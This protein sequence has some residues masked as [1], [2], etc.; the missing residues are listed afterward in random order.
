VR[1]QNPHHCAKPRPTRHRP[2]PEPA[3]FRQRAADEAPPVARTR[4]IPPN[5]GRQRGARPQNPHHSAKPRSTTRCP[6]SEPA[7]LRQRA[8]R[9]AQ[10][11]VRTRTIPPTRG[12]PGTARRQNPH[13]CAKPRPTTRSARHSPSPEPA[14]LRQAAADDA[15]RQAQPVARTRTIAP[16]RGRR[17]GARPQNPHHCA[18]PRPTTRSARHSPS[19]EPAPFRQA[20]VGKSRPGSMTLLGLSCQAATHTGSRLTRTSIRITAASSVRAAV[21]SPTLDQ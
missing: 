2:S 13:H 6:P 16:S 4:T 11:V 18:K 17:R 15:V 14:P 20:A 9:Q 3:P 19:P 10:P 8:V 21:A 5:R 1:R 7:P 12:P